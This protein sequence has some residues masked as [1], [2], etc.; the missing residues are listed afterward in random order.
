M[1]EKIKLIKSTFLKEK[2]TKEKLCNF[3]KNSEILSMNKECKK[4]EE[5][6]SKKQERKYSVFVSNG[7]SANLLLIQTMMNMG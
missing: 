5:N 3:I 6:F 4:F 1:V 2:E 7:S